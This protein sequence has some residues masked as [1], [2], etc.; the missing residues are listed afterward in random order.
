[1]FLLC[2]A[3]DSIVRLPLDNRKIESIAMWPSGNTKRAALTI[4]DVT[5]LAWALVKLGQ[6]GRFM[7]MSSIN[8]EHDKIGTVLCVDD[9]G[10]FCEGRKNQKTDQ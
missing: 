1:M 6:W 8:L 5:D 9:N 3:Q 2:A 10:A 4:I 7:F